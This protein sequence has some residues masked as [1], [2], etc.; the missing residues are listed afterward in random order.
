MVVGSEA[1]GYRL[2]IDGFYDIYT[3]V[4][5]LG[6]GNGQRFSTVNRD[7]DGIPNSN[8]AQIYG[9]WWQGRSPK[10]YPTQRYRSAS[11]RGATFFSWDST[12]LKTMHMYLR[13]KD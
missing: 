11:D 12:P 2:H 8:H 9:P 5:G 4:D 7:N 1:D 3:E 6:F 10:A 13:R